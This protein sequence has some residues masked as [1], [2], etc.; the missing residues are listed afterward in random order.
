ML[1]TELLLPPKWGAK[2]DENTS[3]VRNFACESCNRSLVS[4]MNC[5]VGFEPIENPIDHWIG[6][7]IIQ[8]PGCGKRYW[9]NIDYAAIESIRDSVPDKVGDYPPMW[10]KYQDGHRAL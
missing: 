9:L 1:K 3:K 8:C 10:P 4:W 7:I 2:V 5:I 6:K